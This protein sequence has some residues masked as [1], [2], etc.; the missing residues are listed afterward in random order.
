MVPAS[1]A[2]STKLWNGEL[3]EESPDE[4]ADLIALSLDCDDAKVHVERVS[5]KLGNADAQTL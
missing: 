4:G 1:A 2:D 5:V 3:F